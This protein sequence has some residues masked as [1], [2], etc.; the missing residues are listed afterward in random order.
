[1]TVFIGMSLRTEDVSVAK[2]MVASLTLPTTTTYCWRLKEHLAK[3][4]RK[5]LPGHVTVQVNK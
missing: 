1:M 2:L 3:I 5:T 4:C